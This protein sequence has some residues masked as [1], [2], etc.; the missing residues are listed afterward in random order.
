MAK[1]REKIPPGVLEG[2]RIGQEASR[3]TSKRPAKAPVAPLERHY[4]ATSITLPE[5]LLLFLQEVALRRARAKRENGIVGPRQ[6]VSA[7]IVDMLERHRDEFD[8]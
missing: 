2:A 4:V 3:K 1:D 6:S 8:K 5:D 7:I